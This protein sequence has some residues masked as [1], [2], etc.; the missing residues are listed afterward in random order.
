[1]DAVWLR[2]IKS[3]GAETIALLFGMEALSRGTA[4][5][6][7]PVDTARILGSDEAVSLSVLAASVVA[8]PAV[9]AAPAL[10]R[11]FSRAALLTAACLIGFGAAMIFALQD[12]SVQVVGFVLRALGV[13]FVSI[14]L[15][16]FV[17]DYVRRGDLGRSEPIR[18]LALG[19]GWIIG[20]IIGVVLS[21]YVDPV[22]P[23]FF[24]G[25][26]MLLLMAVFWRL[27]FRA[28]AGV[29]PTQDRSFANPLR[30]LLEFL[31]QPR[32]LHAWLNATG[33]A[34]FWM[35]F[36]IYTPIYAVSTGLGEVVA[37]V[38]LSLGA[39]GMMLMPIWGWIARRVGIRKVATLTFAG[40]AAGCLAAW[41]LADAPWL[42]AAGI[43]AAAL[44]MT[45]NDGYGNALFFRACRPARRTEMTPA[46]TTYRD[47]AEISHAISFAI[48][49]SFLPIETVYFV[50]ALVL[51]ALAL[52]SRAIHP[53]L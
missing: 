28:A 32:L 21:Q 39:G 51:G 9:F 47:M 2:R 52:L 29:R 53:R 37:G 4:S 35:S 11:R 27:R 22:A 10:A 44:S 25:A 3:P 5:V 14:C 20:P 1:L 15:N 13:A 30:N 49:L 46:F 31:R 34:M 18:M 33:R 43:L 40:G 48:L 24:S 41:A 16:L 45:V 26:M 7:L 50:L 23:Y 36:F 8:I 6:A 17:L 42:G 12:A 19:L 38:L